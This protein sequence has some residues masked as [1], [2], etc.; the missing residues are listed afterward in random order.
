MN[1]TTLIVGIATKIDCIANQ[2][3][4]F[5]RVSSYLTWINQQISQITSTSST[6]S[7]TTQ[8][9]TSTQG[10]TTPGGSMKISINFLAFIFS[11]IVLI[12]N[13]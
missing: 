7:T 11:L 9:L 5:T 12:N 4:L 3:A 6:T 13:F 1:G 8:S 10:S 2:P